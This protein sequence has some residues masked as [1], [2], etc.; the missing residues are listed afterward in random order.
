MPVTGHSASY[1]DSDSRAV[2]TP[3][4]ILLYAP[5]VAVLSLPSAVPLPVPRLPKLFLPPLLLAGQA[6][7]RSLS[8]VDILSFEF[9]NHTLSIF[10]S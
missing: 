10:G 4:R 6:L 7:S 3:L 1:I 9:R 2:D 8:F 5:T